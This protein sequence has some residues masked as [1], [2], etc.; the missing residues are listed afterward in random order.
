MRKIVIGELRRNWDLAIPNTEINR[1]Y[2]ASIH[3]T[4]TSEY[5]NETDKYIH[6]FES[7]ETSSFAFRTSNI[8]KYKELCELIIPEGFPM[9]E[10]KA[11]DITIYI[12]EYGTCKIGPDKKF[13]TLAEAEKSWDKRE[14]E[15]MA[16]IMDDILSQVL[17]KYKIKEKENE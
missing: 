17:Q 13:M 14:D 6:Y 16:E 2:I 8:E 4:F 7:V 1:R 10:I 11:G 9:R 3:S 15:I 5:W 12:N